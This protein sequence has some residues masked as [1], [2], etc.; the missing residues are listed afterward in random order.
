MFVY[1]NINPV[2]LSLGPIKLYWYGILY[3]VSFAVIWVLAVKRGTRL[4]HNWT[5]E[6]ISDLIFYGALGVVI[7][8]RVGEMLFYEF[9]DFIANPWSLFA[10]WRGGMSFHGGLLGVLISLYFFSRKVKWNFA[11][12]FD[13]IAPFVPIG[14]FLGRMGNFINCELWGRVTQVPWAMIY[15]LV[16]KYPRHPSQLYEAFSEGILLFVVLWVYSSKLKPRGA[17]SAM[18]LIGYG[19]MRF[20]CEFF[21]EPDKPLTF[22]LLTR[23][24]LLSLPM[25]VI[26]IGILLFI[27]KKNWRKK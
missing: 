6:Q 14:L 23:G 16:D 9:A 15:P 7:G 17:V 8:G 25:M 26:G 21:R 1:P 3:V 27:Y 22:D 4:H 18:F 13:F 11:D 19:I 10:I 20:V 2:A 24:Q 12:V 5:K